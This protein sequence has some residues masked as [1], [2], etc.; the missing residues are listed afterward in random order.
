[1]LERSL[2]I[3][4]KLRQFSNRYSGLT[5]ELIALKFEIGIER[6]TLTMRFQ[7]YETTSNFIRTLKVPECSTP[8]IPYLKSSYQYQLLCYLHDY[9]D[10]QPCMSAIAKFL[11]RFGLDYLNIGEGDFSNR[12]FS[13]REQDRKQVRQVI[14]DLFVF[15][16]IVELYNGRTELRLSKEYVLTAL[17]IFSD[18]TI[19]YI[20]YGILEADPAV[21]TGAFLKCIEMDKDVN[22]W[23]M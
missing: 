17:E 8:T 21:K 1:M 9:Q 3:N 19:L 7:S 4:D 23:M 10:P 6:L 11:Q 5:A 13:L 20:L 14:E 15:L 22:V 16:Y 2:T 12:Y 18:S